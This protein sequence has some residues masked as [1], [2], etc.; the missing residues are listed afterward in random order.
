MSVTNVSS[1]TPK[2]EKDFAQTPMWFVE[3]L[4]DFIGKKNF[5]LDVCANKATSKGLNYFSLEENGQDS[6]ILDW[7]PNDFCNPPFSN[8]MPFIEKAA[9]EAAKGNQ[10]CMIM[11][12]NPETAY[13]RKAKELADT[14]IEMP[15]RLKFLRPD[16][17]MFLDKKGKE[18]GP[19][20]SCL[21]AIF[22]PIGLKCPTRNIYHDFRIGFY[23]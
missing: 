2:N 11:P 1:S 10:T 18:S 7:A 12:N 17:G 15:F 4:L 16:G 3:S 20:F 19:L 21:V 22:T 14:I 6:L 13:V 8:I 23:K 9:Y 5:V